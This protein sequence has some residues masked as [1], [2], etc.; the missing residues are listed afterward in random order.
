MTTAMNA[1]SVLGGQAVS[2]TRRDIP[3]R[4]RYDELFHLLR[5]PTRFFHLR[6]ERYGR[7]FKSRLI[8]PCVF[9]VGEEANRTLMITKRAEFSFGGGYA[10]TAVR[11][12]FEN[13]IMLQDGE[14]H[15]RTRE[16]LKPALGR[17]ALRESVDAVHRI[18]TRNLERAPPGGVDVYELAQRT[19][20]EVAAN[21]LNGLDLGAETDA[22][23]PHF[24]ALIQG[25]MAPL[26]VRFPFGKLDRALKARSALEAVLGPRVVAARARESQGLLGQLAH[27][28][29]PDGTYL[30]VSE[31]VEHLLLLAWASYDTTA[32]AASWI[33]H[34]LASRTDWQERLRSALSQSVAGDAAALEASRELAE[35]EWF[36]LEIE[37]M[38]PSAL[39][40]PRIALADVELG[41]YLVPRG[42]VVFYTPYMSHRDP[43]AFESPNAFDPERFSPARG[44]NRASPAKLF[45]FGGGPR[46]CL[47]KAFA[48]LQLK[49]AV[50]A[51]LTRYRI[52]PDPTCRPKVMG[53]P[54]HHPV[55]SRI[56]LERRS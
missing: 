51:A 34:V 53:L 33:F 36:L 24:E 8:Y 23:R 49:L 16:I 29:A 10:R 1:D 44:A 25:I 46:V 41:G 48:K 7:V 17:L 28:R 22:V 9:V 13:S 39:F 21:V 47:G 27:H 12:V 32:S 40:F 52:H 31:I 26:P 6:F 42:A 45:G 54:V 4:D 3:G 15:E 19:T 30:P 35:L 5:D 18:W 2:E 11:R 37:R 20:F 56:R 50:Q 55:G 38:Y 43:A 14:D